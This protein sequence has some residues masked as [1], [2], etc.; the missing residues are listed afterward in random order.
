MKFVREQFFLAASAQNLKRLVS[1]C[2][3]AAAGNRDRVG[4]RQEETNRKRNLHRERIGF[5]KNG[6]FQHPLGFT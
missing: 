4:P 3:P 2:S 6:G 5:K 1:P